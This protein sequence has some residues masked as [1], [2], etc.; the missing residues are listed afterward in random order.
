[1]PLG[2]VVFAILSAALSKA[3][4]RPRAR[5]TTYEAFSVCLMIIVEL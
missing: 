2:I 3:D 4:F 5:D 1:M